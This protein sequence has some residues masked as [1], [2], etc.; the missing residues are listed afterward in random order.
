MTDDDFTGLS[1][2]RILGG[3]GA[4]GAASV[5]AGLGTSA[6]FSDTESFENSVLTA[7]QLNLLVDY[8]SWWDQGIAGS[9]QVTGTADGPSVS[10]ELTDVKPGDN[11]LLAFCPQSDDNP[12]YLW[13]CGDLVADDENTITEPE[14][15]VDSTPNDG[16][17]AEAIELTVS[18]CQLDDDI[19]D[20]DDDDPSNDGFEPSDIE[21]ST[22]VWTGTLADFL[23]TI[24]GGVPLDGEGEEPAEGG[25]FA[26]GDQNCYAGTGSEETNPCLC[27]DWEVP[28]EVGNEIQTDSVEFDLTFHAQQCRHTDGTTNPCAGDVECEPCDLPTDPSGSDLISVNSVDASAFPDVSA[29]LNVDTTAGNNGELVDDITVC[30]NGLAQDETV[31]FTEDSEADIVFV[32][33][34][35]GSMGGEISGVQSA[36]G[37]FIDNLVTDAGIDA[38]FALISFKDTVELDQDWTSDQ[39]TIQNAVNGLSASGGNDSREDDFDGIGVATRDI[40]ADSGGSLSSYRSGAQ[41]VIIDITDAPAQTDDETAEFNDPTRTDYDISDVGD[42]LSGYTYIAVSPGDLDGIFG[43]DTSDGDKQVLATNV[44][45]TH[46]DIN[47]DEIST[48][49][50]DEISGQ[51]AT[52]YSVSY[53][54][55]D[56][57]S[58]PSDRTILFEVVD[59][60]EGTLYKTATF[61]VP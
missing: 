6:Y 59:P 44:G 28:T 61:T 58:D 5:G 19:E 12:A 50:T 30:E 10:A 13:L 49:L 56:D 55:C 25:F 40:A 1:R 57:D 37:D 4:I 9:G 24:G 8:Y 32:F 33:D 17:L 22:E 43:F 46:I 36:L 51:L 45:G 16:E 27:I 20:A 39:T 47:S 35:T 38:R 31:N 48:I 52:T 42:L 15:E 23:T 41:K 11:G 18:Y 3:L 34:D 29:F 54:S 53:T 14:G 26:P 21:S 60:E 7:G 2:R